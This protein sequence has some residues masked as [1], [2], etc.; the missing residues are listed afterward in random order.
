MCPLPCPPGRDYP[1]RVSTRQYKEQENPSETQRISEG[2]ST[3]A[4]D[5]NPKVG[6]SHCSDAAENGP[7]TD[8]R[9]GEGQKVKQR[10][11]SAVEVRRGKDQN[12]RAPSRRARRVGRSSWRDY[13]HPPSV[14]PEQSILPAGE[15]RPMTTIGPPAF[16]TPYITPLLSLTS[17]LA[18]LYEGARRGEEG[19]PVRRCLARRSPQR[20]TRQCRSRTGRCRASRSSAV[21]RRR[22]GPCPTC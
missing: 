17:R 5:Y 1:P 9:A 16:G 13:R 18:A 2:I 10:H 21:P 8:R 6:G 11:E 7:I 15:A 20:R 19:Q 4:E 14:I 3:G 12:Q 22:R